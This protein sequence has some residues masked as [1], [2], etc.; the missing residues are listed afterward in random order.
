MS[1]LTRGGS[2][3]FQNKESKVRKCL[4]NGEKLT[5]RQDFFMTLIFL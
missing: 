4:Q 3:S 1:E 5:S 2:V